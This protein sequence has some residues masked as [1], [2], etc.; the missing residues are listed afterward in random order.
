M[1][2][3]EG[4]AALFRVLPRLKRLSFKKVIDLRRPETRE[5]L[6]RVLRD[7]PNEA[8]IDFLGDRSS[9]KLTSF[10]LLMPT[11]MFWNLGGNDLSCFFGAHAID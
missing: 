5:W 7:D 3:E 6:L 4:G 2:P 8:R 1:R 9:F 10:E 11:L